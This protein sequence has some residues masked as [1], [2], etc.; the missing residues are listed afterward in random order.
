MN[1]ILENFSPSHAFSALLCID[2]Q[3]LVES[4]STQL[5]T[6]GFEVHT[7]ATPEQA[8]SQL[9]SRTFE[10]LLVSDSFGGGD[11]QAHPVLSQ[12]AAFALD[13]RRKLYVVLIGANLTPLSKMQAFA[14]SVELILRPQDVA[15]LKTLMG[16]ELV[17]HEAF[18][19][20]LR[21]TERLLQ[22]D[23]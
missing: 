14:L 22:K 8:L 11:A 19:A 9:Y 7:A 20:P 2:S 3:E 13:I 21:A 16:Q 12:L 18:Y 17:A 1:P 5:S 10:V 4:A 6:L 15:N 23:G